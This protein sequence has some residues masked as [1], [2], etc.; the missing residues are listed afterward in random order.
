MSRFSG[1][2]QEIDNWREGVR[3]VLFP[4]DWAWRTRIIISRV[5]RKWFV[6]CGR[7]DTHSRLAHAAV[8]SAPRAP[9]RFG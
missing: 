6:K 8:D 4:S 5:I 1:W 3:S 2:D 9:T 7:E